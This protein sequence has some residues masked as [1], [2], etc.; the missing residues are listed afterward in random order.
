MKK[1]DQHTCI[2]EPYEQVQH[3]RIPCKDSSYKINVG[4]QFN[5]AKIGHTR[6]RHS[7]TVVRIVM[8]PQETSDERD[9]AKR[10]HVCVPTIVYKADIPNNAEIS[11][12]DG[13]TFLAQ[14]KNAADI[15]GIAAKITQ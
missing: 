5:N 1:A 14:S 12:L 15:L 11:H 9:E 6:H 2:A 4:E 10:G 13:Q 7:A 3:Y 8:D